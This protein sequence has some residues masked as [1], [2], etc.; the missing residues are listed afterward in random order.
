MWNVDI[1]AEKKYPI[2]K[3]DY[4]GMKT[5]RIWNF[6]RNQQLMH[7]RDAE[8]NVQRGKK[9]RTDE[10]DEEIKDAFVLYTTEDEGRLTLDDY[11]IAHIDD[12]K[13]R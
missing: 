5:E 2:E 1:N 7:I 8:V 3:D 11:K 9:M 4:W 12:E 13:F 10:S 6:H